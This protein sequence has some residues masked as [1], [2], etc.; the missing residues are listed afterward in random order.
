M[1]NFGNVKVECNLPYMHKDVK[2]VKNCSLTY[3]GRLELT[4]SSDAM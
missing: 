3:W 4:I 1:E 2:F